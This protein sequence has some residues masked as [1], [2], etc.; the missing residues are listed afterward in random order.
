LELSID[1]I[2]AITKRGWAKKK[3]P[4]LRLRLLKAQSADYIAA[5]WIRQHSLLKQFRVTRQSQC[6]GK[7]QRIPI[8]QKRDV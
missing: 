5:L 3:K 1:V 7:F 2:H 4:R 8:E 6:I